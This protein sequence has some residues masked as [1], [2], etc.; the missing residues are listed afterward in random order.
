[1][2]ILN[3]YD[4]VCED[5]KE[6]SMNTFNKCLENKCIENT[7]TNP[8]YKYSG[9]I[10][11]F[12]ATI[13]V[14]TRESNHQ[15]CFLN[16]CTDTNFYSMYDNILNGNS[17]YNLINYAAEHGDIEL[18]NIILYSST[19]FK[20]H[21]DKPI[22]WNLIGLYLGQAFCYALINNQ[23][24][25]IQVYL[26][27]MKN[28]DNIIKQFSHLFLTDDSEDYILD[29]LI[30]C[31]SII[32]KYITSILYHCT[33]GYKYLD[34][35]IVKIVISEEDAIT[36]KTCFDTNIIKL[37]QEVEWINE[38]IN[39]QLLNKDIYKSYQCFESLYLSLDFY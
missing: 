11:D 6:H 34:I 22:K 1:M 32:F 4:L 13:I 35:S 17:S 23:K 33:T 19:Y 7:L 37:S 8:I 20:T 38:T 25:I 39:E 24:N 27:M 3:L 16:C 15:E 31:Y 14:V 18:F 12:N 5:C 28:K 10:T 9:N 36:I 30:K 26:D 21:N 2:S 29:S